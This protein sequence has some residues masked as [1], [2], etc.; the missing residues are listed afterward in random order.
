[1]GEVEAGE[2]FRVRLKVVTE[3]LARLDPRYHGTM[4]ED[5]E[6]LRE[7]FQAELDRPDPEGQSRAAN[8]QAK[9]DTSKR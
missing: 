1:M 3:A 2:G 5:L 9:G 4:I 8:E 7:R 6:Q